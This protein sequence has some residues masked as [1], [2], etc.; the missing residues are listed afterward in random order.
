MRGDRPVSIVPTCPRRVATP[1]ARGSTSLWPLPPSR[2]RGYPAC[3]GIDPIPRN[4]RHHPPRLPRM[5]GDRPK[6]NAGCGIRNTATPHARGSTSDDYRIL[7][8]FYGYPACAGIDL[9]SRWLLL[10]G[11]W[12]PRMRGDR[13]SIATSRAGPIGA[14]PHARGSTPHQHRHRQPVGGYP[15]CAGIDLRCGT[16]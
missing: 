15:A 6:I 11:G 9:V 16:G 4:D 8:A 1:H 13:P 5:R 14:T 2:R 10:Q 7:P 3:A 12:L